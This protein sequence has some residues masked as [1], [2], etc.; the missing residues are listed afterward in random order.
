MQIEKNFHFDDVAISLE[1]RK[2]HG[3]TDNSTY[4]KQKMIKLH[5]ISRNFV[6]NHPSTTIIGESRNITYLKVSY[7]IPATTYKT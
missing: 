3:D 4:K 6:P 7:I 2:P 1:T 5:V